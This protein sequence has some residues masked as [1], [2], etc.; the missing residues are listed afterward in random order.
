MAS[1]SDTELN[2]VL[3]G[4]RPSASAEAALRRQFERVRAMSAV[5]RVRL[6]LELGEREAARE[7]DP[8]RR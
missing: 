1:G 4:V 3:L 7:Q 2:L 8:T 5:D 6:A